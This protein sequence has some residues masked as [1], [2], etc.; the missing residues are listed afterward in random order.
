MFPILTFVSLLIA[1]AFSGKC[2]AANFICPDPR[3]T[4][5]AEAARVKSAIFWTGKPLPGNWYAPC[6][7]QVVAA[8]HSGGGMTQFRFDDGEVHSWSMKVEGQRAAILQD[9]IP[10]EVDHAVRA[11]LVRH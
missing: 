5:A 3:I 7:I 6:P 10:H 11:S 9:V 2:D 8:N 1:L 4:E